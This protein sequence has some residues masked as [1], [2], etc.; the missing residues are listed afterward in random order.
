MRHVF[1]EMPQAAHYKRVS[2]MWV[3]WMDSYGVYYPR[4]WQATMLKME[5][6]V[7][8]T[9]NIEYT[10]TSVLQELLAPTESEGSNEPATD[11]PTEEDCLGDD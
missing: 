1:A 8:E 4:E 5:E 3:R 2:V 10:P 6:L 11:N 9:P 7:D